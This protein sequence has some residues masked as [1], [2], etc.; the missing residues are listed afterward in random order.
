MRK[1]CTLII[2]S[3]C[4]AP[5]LFADDRIRAPLGDRFDRPGPILEWSDERPPNIV[6]ILSDD[7]GWNQVGYHGFDYYETPNTDRIAHEGIWFSDAYSSASICSPTRAALMTGKTPARLHITV[8][9]ALTRRV[10]VGP[11]VEPTH[12]VALPLETSTLAEIL[13]K[14]GYVTGHFGKWHLSPDREFEPGR[15]FDPGSRGFDEVLTTLKPS[16]GV[17]P[18]DAH[19]ADLISDRAVAFIEANRDR[20]FFCY[21]SHNVVHQPL[22]EDPERVARFENKPGAD[23]PVNHAIMAA[24]IERMDE[25]IGRILDT[26]DRLGLAENTIVIFH[27]DNGGLMQKQSQAPLRAGKG[28]LYEGGIRVPTCLRWPAVVE[29]G[30]ISAEPV[31]THDFFPTLLRA[32]GIPYS[33][34]HVDGAD[35]IPLLRGETVSAG[36]PALFWHQPNYHH[37]GEGPQSAIRWGDWKL[38]ENLEPSMLG[39]PGAFELFNLAH[40]IGEE[41]DLAE[42][43]PA[44]VKKLKGKLDAWRSR[45][46]AGEMTIRR[47]WPEPGDQQ[48]SPLLPLP[49]L[50][51]NW[52]D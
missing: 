45:V 46:G 27:S 42:A 40:D 4:F 1:S 34:D 24:M 11:L 23:D 38:V 14:V 28:T 44:M 19:N 39:G 47:E 3:L 43:M 12:A 20:P 21:V 37:L 41:N 10:P 36:R 29:P 7:Q 6:F 8:H 31:I 32:A 49:P 26:L 17:E 15:L 16:R 22:L 52:R 18:D 48:V 35:L 30:R 51:G 33:P 9:L 2:F 5:F 13:K 50:P 25:G